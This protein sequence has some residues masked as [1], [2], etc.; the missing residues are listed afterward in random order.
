MRRP[1][2]P[3]CIS[4]S[5][6]TWSFFLFGKFH[7]FGT[8]ILWITVHTKQ[9]TELRNITRRT[10]WV[11]LSQIL[12]KNNDICYFLDVSDSQHVSKCGVLNYTEEHEL[13]KNIFPH[14]CY[15]LCQSEVLFLISFIICMGGVLLLMRHADAAYPTWSRF[16]R[17]PG[18][19]S[20]GGTMTT[21][22]FSVSEYATLLPAWRMRWARIL[23]RYRLP[24][25]DTM[26]WNSARALLGCRLCLTARPAFWSEQYFWGYDCSGY[27]LAP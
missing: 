2:R 14:T 1:H 26:A 13:R 21:R 18:K 25:I 3:S 15:W 8:I 5:L 20:R 7:D 19:S 12:S 24:M 6:M 22:I 17:Y 9:K 23:C 11:S 27:N 4:A 10:T 16:R